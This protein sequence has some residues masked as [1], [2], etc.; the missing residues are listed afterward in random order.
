MI[1]PTFATKE[2]KVRVRTNFMTECSTISADTLARLSVYTVPSANASYTAL[3]PHF[4]PPRASLPHTLIMVV[5]D[6]TRPW[7]FIE[8]LETWFQ[9]I[10]AWAK[11]DGSR[12]LEIVREE[13]RERREYLSDHAHTV[14]HISQYSIISS[15]MQNQPLSLFLQPPLFLALFYLSGRV[16]S[17]IILQACQSL[18]SA[19]RPT[20]LTRS[21]IRWPLEEWSVEREESGRSKRTALCRS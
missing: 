13:N 11:G 9:W 17:P 14:P 5:L 4:L 19:Q 20:S 2:M 8:E 7:T 18:L 10:E 15:I 12:E 21:V 16:H 1:S 3:V 6:W